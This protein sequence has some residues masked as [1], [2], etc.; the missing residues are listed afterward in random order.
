VDP[1][2]VAAIITAAAT[3]GAAIIG[4]LAYRKH[5]HAAQAVSESEEEIRD[6]NA[7][8]GRAPSVVFADVTVAPDAPYWHE[9]RGP[10]A[11]RWPFVRL[12]TKYFQMWEAVEGADLP[13]DVTLFN[14]APEP[15]VL[16]EV[17]IETVSV[18]HVPY[19]RAIAGPVPEATRIKR[20]GAHDL[21]LPSLFSRF[22]EKF[23]PDE[24]VTVDVKEVVSTRLAD[25]IYLEANAPYRY[26]LNLIAYDELMPNHAIVRLWAR[27]TAGEVTSSEITVYVHTWNYED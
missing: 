19:G 16:T 4:V 6:H 21:Q 23:D 26:L 14:K 12:T 5:A 22:S 8:T 10:S 1:T 7:E 24:D 2:I 3:L 9:R 13:L 20:A 17:G 15:V 25:P 11:P 27:T 18:A